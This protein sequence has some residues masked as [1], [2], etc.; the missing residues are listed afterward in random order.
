MLNGKLLFVKLDHL[1]GTSQK[2][3]DYEFASITL[4][5]GLDGFKLPLDLAILP[6]AKSLNRGE[7]VTVVIDVTQDEEGN[8]RRDKNQN[9]VLEVCDIKKVNDV[10]KVS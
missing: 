4:S 10:K 6:I 3:N 8:F 7:Q 5:D 9:A 2:G 1:K